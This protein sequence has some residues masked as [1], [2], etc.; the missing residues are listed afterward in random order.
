MRRVYGRYETQ[1]GA[2][3]YK[4]RNILEIEAWGEGSMGDIIQVYRVW[5]GAGRGICSVRQ[6][7]GADYVT[8]GT[9][10]S[11]RLSKKWWEGKQRVYRYLESLLRIF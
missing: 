11:A 10:R 3:W 8:C 7:M 4:V 1:C 6:F 5:R 9:L 2:S